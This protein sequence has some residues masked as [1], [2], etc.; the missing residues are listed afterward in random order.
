MLLASPL[1]LASRTLRNRIVSAPM[2]RNYCE[3]DGT[4]T[5]SY[6]EYLAERAAGG[7]AL[8]YT[9]ATYVRQDGKSRTNQMGLSDDLHRP[10]IRRLADRVHAEGSLLGIQLMHGGR[11]SSRR[12]SGLPPVAPTAIA[13]SRPNADLPE[14]LTLDGIADLI[15]SFR[16]ATVRAVESG[17]DVL[18]LHGAHGYLLHS[19]MS[20]LTNRRTDRY[21]DP[22]LFVREVLDAVIAAAEGI[23]VG[24]RI[25][26]FEGNP[27]GLTVEQQLE[28]FGSLDPSRLAFV[29]VSAGNY[30][31]PQ[32][33]SQSGEFPRAGL[34]PYAK[35]YRDF[36]IPVGVAGH[37]ND[38]E[39]AE[40][41]LAGE[42]A[43]YVEVARSLHADPAA[44]RHWLQGTT[45]RPCISCNLCSDDLADGPVRCSVNPWVAGGKPV[46]RFSARRRSAV[47]VGGGPAGLE[48]ARLL[49]EQNYQVE[50]VDANERVG[51]QFRLA[52]GLKGVPE[53]H[54]ILDW[55]ESTLA[56]L[57]VTVTLRTELD[58]ES[59]RA[60]RPDVVLI[61]TGGRGI[62]STVP[63]ATSPRVSDVREWLAD[64]AVG[65]EPLTDVTILGGDREALALSYHLASAGTRV[66]V[67]TDR[68]D[69]AAE[70]GS[71]AKIISA[72]YVLGSPL[73]TQLTGVSL[74]AVKSDAV[75][76]LGADGRS[77]RV[78]APGPVIVTNG[79]SRRDELMAELSTS[80]NRFRVYD[81]SDNG[82]SCETYLSAVTA[83]G[84]AVKRVCDDTVEP[85]ASG[86]RSSMP[87]AV[88][89]IAPLAVDEIDALLDAAWASQDPVELELCRLRIAALL[90]D[91]DGLAARTPV[92]SAAGLTEDTIAELASWWKS[93][94]FTDREKARI[95]Y[96]EQFVV[97]VSSMGDDEVAALLA[98]DDYRAVYDFT[99]AIY[100]LDMTA[101]VSL[102]TRAVLGSGDRP[103][104][105][106]I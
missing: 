104:Q 33:M 88:R 23:P 40:G 15:E 25:S 17:V 100:V 80:A 82:A 49:A 99:M 89:R 46:L 24:I 84:L 91:T 11:T 105:A 83:A 39:T 18:S 54:R 27:G 3:P 26:A 70:V 45:Y 31:A 12:A 78:A 22:A 59:I 60:R 29:D 6:I 101:R 35:A 1:S 14:E 32:W 19:F 34:A 43:D 97:S 52:A 65:E 76:Y 10:G 41:V 102:M 62:R 42:F 50:L 71:R 98:D 57:G 44:A 67:I 68:A 74:L 5:D 85:R 2:E 16:R 79:T 13:L 64:R 66:T 81:V 55:Y 86:A 95:A 72:P 73:V 77:Q 8:V 96:A 92:A 103:G 87:D 4:V 37:I 38:P 7:A 61:A 56:G 51:G 94:A 20:P 47:I 90:G 63:G 58:A 106:L 9:E 21:A 30:E 69:V 28:I 75:V 53:Y 36:G 48:S 93:D